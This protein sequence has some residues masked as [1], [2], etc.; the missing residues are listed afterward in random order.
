[1]S[2]KLSKEFDAFTEAL[3]KVLSVSHV[4]IKRREAAY[5]AERKIEKAKREIKPPASE[6]HASHEKD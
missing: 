5:M 1:M 4:E 2:V 6:D 3:E